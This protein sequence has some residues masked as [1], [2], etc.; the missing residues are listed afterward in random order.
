MTGPAMS[1]VARA[2]FALHTEYEQRLLSAME[3]DEIVGW[4]EHVTEGDVERIR[5]ELERSLTPGRGGWPLAKRIIGRVASDRE[6][7]RRAWPGEGAG[8]RRSDAGDV[9]G[10]PFAAVKER[11]RERNAARGYGS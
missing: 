10:D 11:H 2:L 8:S 1:E 6:H 9:E 3:H 5:A 7:G 4:S